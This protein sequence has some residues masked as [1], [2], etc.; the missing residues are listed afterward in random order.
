[1]T[2]LSDAL[3]KGDGEYAV[4]A[5]AGTIDP[6][7]TW[8]FNSP[9]PNTWLASVLSLNA[10]GPASGNVTVTTSTTGS[11]LDPDGYTVTV[12]GT[13]SQAIATNGSV[14][15]SGLSAGSHAVAL[16]GVAANCTV[17]GGTHKPSPCHPVGPRRRFSCLAQSAPA[18]TRMTS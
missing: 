5:T 15:F 2:I 13:Q 17:S 7:W 8:F 10:A 9:T 4:P 12:G 11:N 14:T 3:L 6:R 1:V 16:S 18:G